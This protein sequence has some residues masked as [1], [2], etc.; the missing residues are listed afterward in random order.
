MRLLAHTINKEKAPNRGFFF[1]LGGI[2]NCDTSGRG[3]L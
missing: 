3:T 1:G 2:A